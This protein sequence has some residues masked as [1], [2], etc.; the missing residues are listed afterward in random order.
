MGQYVGEYCGEIV[1]NL[2]EAQVTSQAF[3][4]KQADWFLSRIERIPIIPTHPVPHSRALFTWKQTGHSSSQW[5]RHGLGESSSQACAE[6]HWLCRRSVLRFLNHSCDPNCQL[7]KV[8]TNATDYPRC[9]APDLQFRIVVTCCCLDWG[10]MPKLES[11][12]ARS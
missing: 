12:R 5:M 1:D 8:M 4:F 2:I 11:A 9:L 6:Y 7:V 10:F 3:V